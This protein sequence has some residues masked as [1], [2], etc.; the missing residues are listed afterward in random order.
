MTKLVHAALALCVMTSAARGAPAEPLP[1]PEGPRG[2]PVLARIVWPDHDLTHAQVR[3][4]ADAERTKLVDAF[5][6][7]GA[8]GALLL[9]L[10]PGTYWLMAYV[11]VDGDGKPGPG[12]GIG[13]YGVTDV[14]SRPRPFV[15]DPGSDALTVLI[16]I[17]FKIAADGKSLEP[18]RVRLPAP[19]AAVRDTPISGR[20]TGGTGL[21]NERLVL[22]IPL[23]AHSPPRAAF[24]GPDGTFHLEAVPG[25]YYLVAIENLGPRDAIG[26]GDLVGVPYYE[27]AMGASQPTLRA[28]EGDTLEDIVISLD[29]ALAGDGRLRSGDGSV[30]GPRLHLG[31]LPAVV[32]G[33]VT[34]LG[35]PVPGAH[36]RAYADEDL[37]E[38]HYSA[39][40]DEHGRFCMGVRPQ[41]YYL[42]AMRDVDGD[43]TMGPGDEL[44]FFGI[45]HERL[46][47][48][49]EPL[50]LRPGELRLEGNIPLV[51]VVDHDN[52]PVPLT[53]PAEPED[54]AAQAAEP[55]ETEQ[56]AVPVE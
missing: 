14:D 19:Y 56:H 53:A 38:L 39:T 24:V 5:P 41:S 29:W 43:G 22:L 9:A 16:P 28:G 55:T 37:S 10:N 20:V 23:A 54:E 42:V 4:Y 30:L 33:V 49:P 13:F 25:S 32:A 31:D 51:M 50:A 40:A 52:R 36:V 15:V 8:S 46:S 11:D 45:D 17:S 44:G 21:D 12:D 7:G 1:T 47:A 18:V 27:P 48:R 26:R 2:V 34:R 6:S 35:E 3:V